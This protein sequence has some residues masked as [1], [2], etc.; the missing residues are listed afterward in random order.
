LFGLDNTLVDRAGAFRNWAR[1]FLQ[2]R[3][4]TATTKKS[5]GSNK[6]IATGLASRIAFFEKVRS[7]YELPDPVAG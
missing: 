7:H 6:R 2:Q 4:S 5:S 3:D 1:A